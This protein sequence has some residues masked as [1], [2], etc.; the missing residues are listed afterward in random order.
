MSKFTNKKWVLKTSD[1][2]EKTQNRSE[3]SNALESKNYSKMQRL[4]NS[5]VKIP[6]DPIFIEKYISDKFDE[7]DLIKFIDLDLVLK[8]YIILHTLLYHVTDTIRRINKI[9]QHI[10]QFKMYLNDTSKK[11]YE[12]QLCAIMLD[13]LRVYDPSK[14]NASKRIIDLLI[15][16]QINFNISINHK[17][18]L[19]EAISNKFNDIVL[20]L[21]NKCNADINISTGNSTPLNEAI[22]SGNVE[23]V[24]Q[25]IYMPI[26][27]INYKH[28]LKSRSDEKFDIIPEMIKSNLDFTGCVK[29]DAERSFNIIVKYA[30][31]DDDIKKHIPTIATIIDHSIIMEILIKNNSNQIF[32]ELI[33]SNFILYFDEPKLMK[34]ADESGNKQIYQLLSDRITDLMVAIHNCDSDAIKLLLETKN[35]ISYEINRLSLTD[36]VKCNDITIVRYFVKHGIEDKSFSYFTT[37]V[38]PFVYPIINKNYE[39]VKLLIDLGVNPNVESDISEIINLPQKKNY[40][41]L[42]KITPLMIAISEND[43]EIVKMLF[44][45]GVKMN[46]D[47]YN[48]LIKLKYWDLFKILYDKSEWFNF[49]PFVDLK[50]IRDETL[51]KILLGQQYQQFN[52]F[53]SGITPIVYNYIQTNDSEIVSQLNNWNTHHINTVDDIRSVI[54]L[55]QTAKDVDDLRDKKQILKEYYRLYPH[56]LMDRFILNN[57]EIQSH[58][59]YWNNVSSMLKISKFEPTS[60]IK[61]NS[62]DSEYIQI[63]NKFFKDMPA[64]DLTTINPGSKFLVDSIYRVNIPYQENLWKLRPI[65]NS[66]KYVLQLW[67]G[68]RDENLLSIL[69]TGFTKLNTPYHNIV[70]LLHGQAFG[71][72]VYFADLSYK[73]LFYSNE[74]RYTCDLYTSAVGWLFL[75]TVDIKLGDEHTALISADKYD[76]KFNE[77]VIP[78]DKIDQIKCDYLLKIKCKE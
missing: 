17:V 32:V 40:A 15:N 38:S 59:D 2:V 55:L 67:H 9:D 57:T 21:I 22:E 14:N 25:L 64:S 78:Y 70:P 68:T 69:R 46:I 43:I 72:G 7:F 20:D 42:N 19:I 52:E 27:K 18:P 36:V 39:I 35:D 45:A 6:D 12:K 66:S 1:T 77:Y 71:D 24:K 26:I 16:S 51:S 54:K 34:V 53:I 30:N 29:W 56:A 33:D 47:T 65:K 37:N 60:L 11:I 8:H 4:L 63:E 3:I 31:N 48:I 50:S 13:S 28:L 23:I 44:A 73:S 74:L 75:C 5:G 10:D 76:L 49:K 58:I 41:D 61:L 62:S